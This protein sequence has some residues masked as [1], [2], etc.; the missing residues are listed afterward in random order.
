MFRRLFPSSL[1]LALLIQPSLNVCSGWDQSA[2]ARMA[3]CMGSND[4]GSQAT[5][6]T[7]CASGEHRQTAEALGS[8]LRAALPVPNLTRAVIVSAL[9][10]VHGSTLDLN[11][12]DHV[13]ST[14]DT[15][16]LLSVFLI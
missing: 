9:P 11:Q 3:C 12:R 1:L 4:D 6:D 7:C 2:D 16:L 5:V 10:V 14:S 13:A 15:H 8:L